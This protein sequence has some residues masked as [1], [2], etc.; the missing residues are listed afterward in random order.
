MKGGKACKTKLNR[1]ILI[2]ALFFLSLLSFMV[3][4]VS[5]CSESPNESSQKANPPESAVQKNEPQVEAPVKEEIV[6]STVPGGTASTPGGAGQGTAGLGDVTPLDIKTIDFIPARP[7]AGEPIKVQ[8]NFNKPDAASVPLHYR[9]QVNDETVQGADGNAL[10]YQTK[11]GDRIDVLVFVGNLREENRARR[12]T[13]VVDN[14]PP[15]VKKLEEHLGANGEYVARLEA[16][17]PDD[18][19]VALKLQKGPPGMVLDTASQELRWSIPAG[20]DGTFPVELQAS[21]PVGASVLF[22]YS[23]TI[24]QQQQPAGSA[25]NATSVSSPPK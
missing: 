12:A 23:F 9:W 6:A 16:S 5:C 19:M 24:R 15:V 20:T 21:D 25:A 22:S 13:V 8:V 18:D 4:A 11:R 7:I 17:D 1:R 3:F 2:R 14:A 10:G